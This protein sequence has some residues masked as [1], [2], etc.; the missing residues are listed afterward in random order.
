MSRKYVIFTV[1]YHFTVKIQTKSLIF[2]SSSYLSCSEISRLNTR[3]ISIYYR[4]ANSP[5]RPH[6]DF[7]HLLFSE[8]YRC[9]YCNGENNKKYPRSR[10]LTHYLTLTPRIRELSEPTPGST[11]L[12]RIRISSRECWYIVR[13]DRC[14]PLSSGLGARVRYS[15]SHHPLYRS[16]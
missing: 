2:T 5:H 3:K 10:R 1:Y 7:A 6:L 14:T 4:Y 15:Q 13:Y 8:S 9:A 16:Q 11:G 12:T